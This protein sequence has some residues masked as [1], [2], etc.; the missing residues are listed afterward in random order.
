[1]GDDVRSLE[2]YE[3]PTEIKIEKL[4]PVQ[5]I[6]RSPDTAYSYEIEISIFPM[7]DTN[8]ITVS[9]CAGKLV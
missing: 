6:F 7:H 9:F 5:V 4:K 2:T 8:G 1:M 3:T